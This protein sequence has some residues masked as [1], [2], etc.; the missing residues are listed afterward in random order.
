MSGSKGLVVRGY[1]L[2]HRERCVAYR[3]HNHTQ[4]LP[5]VSPAAHPDRVEDQ[6]APG[7]PP[8]EPLSA[9]PIRARQRPIRRSYPLQRDDEDAELTGTTTISL[10]EEVNYQGPETQECLCSDV[11]LCGQR[12]KFLPCCHVF[13]AHCID[14]W[15]RTHDVC[16]VDKRKVRD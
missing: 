12:V 5:A 15:L 6:S 8:I 11:I 16:P 13:H 14:P 3:E 10:F 7:P 9:D 1:L 4:I 2:P